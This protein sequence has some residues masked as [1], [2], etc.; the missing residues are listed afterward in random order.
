[1]SEFEMD[2]DYYTED[3]KKEQKEKQVI[4]FQ[5]QNEPVVKV[6]AQEKK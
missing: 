5:E 6:K 4:K 3:A 2:D 1:M